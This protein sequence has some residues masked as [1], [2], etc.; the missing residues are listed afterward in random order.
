VKLSL[1]TRTGFLF[2]LTFGASVSAAQPVSEPVRFEYRAPAGCPDAEAFVNRVQA[3]TARARLGAAEELARTFVVEVRADASGASAQLSFTDSRG[4]PVVRA[5]RGETC[6]EVVSAIALVTAL[7]IEAGPTEANA[8]VESTQTE[9]RSGVAPAPE[10]AAAPR[11]RALRKPEPNVV[12]WS[13]GAE[14]SVTTWLGPAPAPG[15]GV[16]GE[17]GTYAGASA[18]LTLLGTASSTLV[19]NETLPGAY[20]RANFN[21]LLARIEG[22]PVVAV[23]GWGFRVLPC[24]AIGLGAFR[25]AGE[26]ASVT[27]PRSRTIFWADLVPAL[28]LDWTVA[29]SLVFF[30]QAELGV[31]LVRHEFVFEGPPQPVFEVPA[32]GVGAAFGMAWRF[33]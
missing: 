8:P 10:P 4:A 18:R 28:R 9:P 24:V 30:G 23:V 17:V 13:L 5:V 27:P 15:V 3:R 2:A 31:P 33:P 11:K 14:T 20:R 26:E 16:F 21:A 7:A 12:V 29:D 1:L 19:E 22:C 6:D 25:G 32:V